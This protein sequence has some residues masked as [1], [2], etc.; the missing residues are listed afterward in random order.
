MNEQRKPQ[1]RRSFLR[2]SSFPLIDS[3]DHLIFIDRRNIPCRRISN[4]AVEWV[5]VYDFYD[6]PVDG[7]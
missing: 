3:D 4:I 7:H 1:E 5:S 6:S 2:A